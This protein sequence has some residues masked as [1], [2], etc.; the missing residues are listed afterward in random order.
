MHDY[1][2]DDELRFGHEDEFKAAYDAKRKKEKALARLS[3]KGV[4]EGSDFGEPREILEDVLR[5]LEREVEWPLTDVMDPR[6]VKQLLA[7][8]VK[9]VNDKMM[10]MSEA[11]DDWGSM[12]HRAF[13]RAELQHELGHEDDPDFERKLRQQ[14]M[15]KDR[16]PWYIKIDGK[17]YKQKGE[18]KSFDWKKG[19]NNYALTIL[20]NRPELQGKILLTKKPV[21]EMRETATTGSTSAGNVSVG[22][23]YPNKKAK[24]QKPGKNALDSDNLLTGG[25]LIK[26]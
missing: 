23:V 16:G 8:V 21:D 25:S 4:A 9:A 14:Q 10:S 22:A 20:K 24:K 2:F 5:V 7:P 12:S 15:D 26:R 11:Q 3:R 18:P 6:E 1:D 13:K 19:A 17:I